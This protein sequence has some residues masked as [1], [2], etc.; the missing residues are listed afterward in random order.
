LD[1]RRTCKTYKI[2][3]KEIKKDSIVFELYKE[4]V[5]PKKNGLPWACVITT[6]S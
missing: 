6:E 4:W 2:H 3:F 1:H 5:L